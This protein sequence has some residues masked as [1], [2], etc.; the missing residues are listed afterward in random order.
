LKD[1]PTARLKLK[2]FLQ[3]KLVK[4]IYFWKKTAS[5]KPTLADLALKWPNGKPATT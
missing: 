4:S 2:L 5:K 1:F 3:S